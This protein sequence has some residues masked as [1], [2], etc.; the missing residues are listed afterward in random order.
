MEGIVIERDFDMITLCDL[1]VKISEELDFLDST[2]LI[3]GIKQSLND[4]KQMIVPEF[5]V[6]N[7]IFVNPNIWNIVC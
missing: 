3:V 2:F 5:H 7:H 4:M 6:A 1:G